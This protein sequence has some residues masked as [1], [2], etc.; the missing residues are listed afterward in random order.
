MAVVEAMF[1]QVRVP[2]ED[3]DL[4]FLWWTD[5]D[6]GRELSVYRM[7]VHIFSATS[8]SSCASYGLRRAAEDNSDQFSFTAVNM[9]L[10]NFYVDDC[11]K[12]MET[13][14]EAVR[15]YK[16]LKAICLRGG[17]KVMKW[18]SNSRAVLAAIPEVERAKE[19]SELDLDRDRLPVERALGVQ[20]CVQSDQFKFKIIIPERAPTRR[21]ILST[22]SSIYDPLGVVSPVVLQ[23]KKLLQ[24]LCRLKARWD[25]I[26]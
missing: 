4:R 21:N 25:D 16:D 18:I 9:V 14:E 3:A 24:E 12:S 20:W 7:V 8:S 17:F 15:L 2:P 10:Q 26:I 13:E 6:L 23:A 1:H 5:G 19:A 22:V 11:L